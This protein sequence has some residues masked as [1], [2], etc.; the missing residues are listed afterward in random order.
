M[1]LEQIIKF[2]VQIILLR[3]EDPTNTI[4][5]N[6]NFATVN[7]IEERFVQ[8]QKQD[9]VKAW[10]SHD[11]LYRQAKKSLKLLSKIFVQR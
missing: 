8:M 1:E 2:Y 6:N 3:R 5:S 11:T 7:S 4:I 10:E 9:I